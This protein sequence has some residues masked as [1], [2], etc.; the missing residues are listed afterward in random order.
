MHTEH[1]F[2]TYIISWQ[3]Y[4]GEAGGSAVF[5]DHMWH[6]QLSMGPYISMSG[7]THLISWNLC[8]C[9]FNAA[10]LR[11]LNPTFNHYVFISVHTI[12][13]LKFLLVLPKG[14]VLTLEFSVQETKIDHQ[15]V[16]KQQLS[17]PQNQPE[18]KPCKPGVNRLNY[19]LSK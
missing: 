11:R 3:S 1:E 10:G 8:S 4:I 15:C 9:A 2:L 18:Q 16:K 6:V 7:I 13:M 14:H 19:K 17:A 12:C 5:R